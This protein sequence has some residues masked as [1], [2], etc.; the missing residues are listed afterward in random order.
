MLGIFIGILTG[1]F[2]GLA[3]LGG[4]VIMIPLMV[5]FYRLEQ[6]H[7]HGTSLVAVIFTGL[8]GTLIYHLHGSMDIMVLCLAVPA[9]LTAHLGALFAETLSARKLRLY[10]GVFIFL[11]GL[12]MVG[13]SYLA[14]PAAPLTGAAKLMILLGS[15]TLAGLISGMMGAGGGAVLVPALVLLVGL[16]Q[17]AAQGSALL[18]MIPMGLSGAYTHWRLGNVVSNI[19]PGLLIGI[20][21]GAYLGG[22][23]AHLLPEADL[24]LAFALI[25]ILIGVGDIRNAL[26]LRP[27]VP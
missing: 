25:I 9:V 5:R 6:H 22:S 2:G 24:R 1:L 7:A 11:V 17:H 21:L 18:A 19:L 8:A 23:L 26:H 12:I 27:P 14:P 20:L 15:G 3:G 10:F 4:S 16:D 13:K